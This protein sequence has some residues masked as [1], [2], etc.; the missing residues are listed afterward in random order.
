M[1]ARDL[2]RKISGLIKKFPMLAVLGPRQSGKTTLLR[3][4][5]PAY[6]YVNLELPETR[7]FAASDPRGFL[8]RYQKGVIL[9][10]IQNVPDL[11]S[12]LQVF[13]DER[14]INGEYVLTGSQHFLMMEQISQSLAGRVALLYLMPF[15]AR[16]LHQGEKP[17]NWERLIFY[18][19]YPRIF[20]QDIHPADFYPAYIQTYIE[21]DV[22]KLQNV[23][24]LNQ[25]R[26]F[27]MLLA[28]RA[29]QLLNVN[30]LAADAGI[31]NHTAEAWIRLLEASFIVFR[32]PPYFKNFNKRVIKSPKLYFCDTGLL[33]SLLGLRRQADAELHFMRGAL[34]ENLVLLEFRKF[35]SNAGEKPDLYFWRDSNQNE[36]DLLFERNGSLHACEIKSGKT[37]TKDYFK[38]LAKFQKIQPESRL[39]LIYG[40]DEQY[41]QLDIRITGF[42]HLTGSA[43]PAIFTEETED[44]E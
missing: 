16:E 6:A 36:I 32:L 37:I 4:L 27:L 10:E 18:G 23:A 31:S 5:F 40:G 13:T 44:A 41:E 1:I 26:K 22:R 29:G 39:H 34:F 3:A 11:F 25:F 24:N 9:D 20:D 33:C 42:T 30:S 19:G 28:G 8:E 35:L 21:R 12:Y 38:G 15:S 43:L 2:T 17:Q 14:G 7:A